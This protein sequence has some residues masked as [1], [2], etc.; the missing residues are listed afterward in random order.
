V[1]GA[2][3]RRVRRPQ[4]GSEMT[5]GE[6]FVRPRRRWAVPRHHITR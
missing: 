3:P 1:V 5:I 4:R 6:R 2:T